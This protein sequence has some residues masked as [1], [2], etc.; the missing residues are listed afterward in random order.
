MGAQQVIFQAARRPFRMLRALA[1]GIEAANGL[2]REEELAGRAFAA[3]FYRSTAADLA[4]LAVYRVQ[5]YQAQV[6]AAVVP[7]GHGKRLCRGQTQQPAT[8]APLN[9]SA[10]LA[11]SRA[12]ENRFSAPVGFRAS[13]LSNTGLSDQIDRTSIQAPPR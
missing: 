9:P 6:R 3:A 11:L 2:A 13:P 7:A 10:P 12:P 1:T 8:L 4:E 5:Q